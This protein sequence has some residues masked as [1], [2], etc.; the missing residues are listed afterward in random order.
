MRSMLLAFIAGV[1]LPSAAAQSAA[2]TIAQRDLIG[3][4]AENGDCRHWLS[5]NDDGT[6]T[7]ADGSTGEWG[8]DGDVLSASVAGA[9]GAS[10]ATVR[11]LPDGSIARTATFDHHVDRLSRCPTTPPRRR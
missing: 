11:R 1:A 7:R 5:Y 10:S 3:R 9:G 2:T 8:L 6:W 4:W